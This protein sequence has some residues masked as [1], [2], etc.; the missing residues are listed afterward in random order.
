[1]N[2]IAGGSG[3]RYR[4]EG[5][6]MSPGFGLRCDRISLRAALV[7]RK[8]A[9]DEPG[10]QECRVREAR[11]RRRAIG[12]TAKAAA[13]GTLCQIR[14]LVSPLASMIRTDTT[15]TPC[16]N[17]GMTPSLRTSTIGLVPRRA[18]VRHFL[19]LTSAAVTERYS[20][21][22]DQARIRE[23]EYLCYGCAS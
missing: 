8:I 10:S 13:A 19:F 6:N 14:E 4:R 15:S 2:D 23:Y 3:E 5:L 17:R 18:T 16:V 22:G 11:L 1:L 21:I 12:A 9:R 7:K 20:D